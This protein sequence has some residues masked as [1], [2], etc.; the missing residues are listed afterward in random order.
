MPR[1]AGKVVLLRGLADG[2]SPAV[3][4]DNTLYGKGTE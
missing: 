1:A 3:L 2:H 4:S